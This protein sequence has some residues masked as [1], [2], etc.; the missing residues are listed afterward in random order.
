MARFA[1]LRSANQSPPFS[2]PMSTQVRRDATAFFGVDY[3]QGC[4]WSQCFENFNFM[5]NFYFSG[6]YPKIEGLMALNDLD[7]DFKIFNYLIIKKL[8]IIA[9]LTRL[10]SYIFEIGQFL[11]SIRNYDSSQK[12]RRK[13]RSSPFARKSNFKVINI[14][15]REILNSG[16]FPPGMGEKRCQRGTV[17]KGDVRH[18]GS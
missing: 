5:K 2:R 11:M 3:L 7:W 4:S 15:G 13:N 14:F 16:K 8:N 6:T 17:L 12:N 1:V 18:A 10:T 9:D